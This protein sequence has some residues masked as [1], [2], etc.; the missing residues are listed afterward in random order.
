[1]KLKGKNR[2][3]ILAPRK[4]QGINDIKRCILLNQVF[5]IVLKKI[6]NKNAIIIY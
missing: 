1:M 2:I 4:G 6:E 3:R 5:T